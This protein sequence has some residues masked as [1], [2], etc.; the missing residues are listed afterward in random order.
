VTSGY[1]RKVQN[2]DRN[3]SLIESAGACPVDLHAARPAN[4]QV[5]GL[6]QSTDYG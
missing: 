6:D 5:A 2:E 3:F 1:W 4:G